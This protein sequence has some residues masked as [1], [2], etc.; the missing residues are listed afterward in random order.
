MKN[1]LMLFALIS[2]AAV[3]VLLWESPP[4]FFLRDGTTR[5]GTLPPAD[6]YMRDTV[7]TKYNREGHRIYALSAQTGL[8]YSSEDRFEL[9][10][11][12]LV[13]QRDQAD[14]SPWQ[15]RASRA[16][17]TQGGHSVVLSGKVYAWQQVK[18]GRNELLTESLHFDPDTNRAETDQRVIINYPGGTSEGVGMR[19]DFNAEVYELLSQVR[20]THYGR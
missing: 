5:T 17:T 7:T 1:L 12:Q 3:F 8:Y 6:S 10:S 18:E 13:A 4:E 11:P 16:H 2:V 15:L 19:A 20:G 9:A 14:D